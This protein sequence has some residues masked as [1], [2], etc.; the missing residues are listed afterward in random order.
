MFGNLQLTEAVIVTLVSRDYGSSPTCVMTATLLCPTRGAQRGDAKLVLSP[1][2]APPTQAAD[3]VINEFAQAELPDQRHRRRLHL[4]ASAFAQ[5]P[6]API[7]QACPSWAEAKASYRFLENDQIA[8][9]AIRQAHHQASLQR[10]SSH[11]VVLAVQDTTTLNYSTHPKTLGL[12]PI[13]SH[14]PKVIGLLL[15][16]TLAITPAGRPL[17]FLHNAV[18]V[19]CGHGLAAKR[20]RRKLTQKESHKWV[21]SLSACQA[22]APLCPQTMLV[23]IAD[24]EADLYELFVQGLS[25]PTEPKVHLLVRARH[26]R[27]LEDADRTLWQEVGRQ[28][29]AATLSVLVGRHGDQ[30]SRVAKLHIRSCPVQLKAPSRKADQPPIALWA[31]EAREISPPKGPAHILWRLLTTLPVTCAQ[32]AIEKVAWYAQRWQIEVIHKVLKSGCQVEQRQLETAQRL[33]RALSVDLVVAWRILALC[34]AAREL[35]E[36]PVSDWLPTAQWQALCCYVH[37]QTRPPK[38]AP[39]VRQAVRWIAQFGG[40]LGRKSDGQPGTQTLW[41]GLQQLDAMTNMWQLFQK[42]HNGKKCG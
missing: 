14:S 15:H 34:K 4:M 32:E 24:R 10:V 9:S 5:K 41:R 35:P 8:P 30:P 26:D 19:R 27:K 23:N 40:F 25:A 1:S 13:G 28:R 38:T 33:E 16:S 36:D 37:Q 20:H 18:R 11:R 39:S 29:V 22:L 7:P 12:G 17:G 42:T 6:T 21:E 31:I 2:K 3:W